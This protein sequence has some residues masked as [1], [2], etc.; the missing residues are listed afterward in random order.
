MLQVER[1][2][3]AVAHPWQAAA[4]RSRERDSLGRRPRGPLGV[5]RERRP[6]LKGAGAVVHKE[7][8]AQWRPYTGRHPQAPDPGVPAVSRKAHELQHH[9]VASRKE[10]AGQ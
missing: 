8:V 3:S 1:T 2:L 9:L 4:L 6:H 7:A 10:R 5:W